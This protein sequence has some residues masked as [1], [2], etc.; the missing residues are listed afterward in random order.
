MGSNPTTL[1]KERMKTFA[2]GDIHGHYDQMMRLFDQL[3]FG[4]NP[5]ANP[6]K[7]I[8]VFMGDYVDGG[9]D[10]KAVL[11]EL[12]S[13][14]EQFPHWKFLFGN[15][16]H[17][18]LDAFNPKHPVYGDYYLWWNQGGEETLNSFKPPRSFGLSDYER[19]IM[20]NTDLITKEYLD[21]MKGLD[22]YYENDDYFFIHAGVMPGLSLDK[23]KKKIDKL[24]PETITEGDY[25]YYGIWVRDEFLIS[26]EDWGKKIIFGHTV[27]PYTCYLKTGP[28]TIGAYGE[29]LVMD[30]KIGIDQMHHN[31]GEMIAVELPT[32]TFFSE[33]S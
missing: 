4:K 18:L 30:N 25:G 2:I 13:L 31:E 33:P 14:K 29:P 19:S 24:T 7:D 21:F 17:L 1:T 5:P 16:E 20:Q 12:I 22:L 8:F 6:N 26:E 23:F 15:H 9:P 28:H 32:E 11:D 27:F 3:M 10:T